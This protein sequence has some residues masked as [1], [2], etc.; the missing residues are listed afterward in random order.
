M[1]W[2][3]PRVYGETP[4]YGAANL[5]IQGLSPRVRG[6]RLQRQRS[7]PLRRSIPACTG[8]PT[9]HSRRRPSAG[10]YPRVYGETPPAEFIIATAAGLS[11]RVRGNQMVTQSAR[12]SA[13]SIPACTGKPSGQHR[14]E[15]R[16]QVYPR[17]YGETHD[18]LRKP[19]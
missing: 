9:C 14:R 17:V 6:N 5:S 13:G 4:N 2:V 3:Y 7:H 16:S 8:K 12:R 11:P 1:T 18:Q 19:M 15:N 10:V